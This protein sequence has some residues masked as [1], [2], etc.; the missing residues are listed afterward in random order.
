MDVEARLERE[1]A[2]AYD[3]EVE[4]IRKFMKAPTKGLVGDP[5]DPEVPHEGIGELT[6]MLS[7]KLPRREDDPTR[8]IV[9][10][11]PENPTL[12]EA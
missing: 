3:L 8:Q 6:A 12:A 1:R 9:F 2:A 10:G 7:G 4:S 5:D 11:I